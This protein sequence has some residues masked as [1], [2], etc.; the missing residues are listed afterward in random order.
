MHSLKGLL[1]SLSLYWTLI[2]FASALGIAAASVR[3]FESEQAKTIRLGM[4]KQKELRTLAERISTYGQTVR[5]QFPT[6]DV[7]VSERDLAGDCQNH[8][9]PYSPR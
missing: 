1:S 4:K 6:G 9:K 3:A 2:V 7:V 8:R 5:R